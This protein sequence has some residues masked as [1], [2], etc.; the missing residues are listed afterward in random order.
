MIL[1]LTMKDYIFDE[2]TVN[3]KLLPPPQNITTFGYESEHTVVQIHRYEY[4]Y[5]GMKGVLSISS[6]LKILP[7][8]FNR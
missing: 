2:V 1:R 6:L 4:L 8:F 7:P 3:F 5:F